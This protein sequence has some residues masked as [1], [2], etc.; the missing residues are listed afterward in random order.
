MP[1]RVDVITD[2]AGTGLP[3]FGNT[4]AEVEVHTGNG[5]GSTNTK[6]RRFS[7]VL[8]DVGGDIDYAESSTLGSSFTINQDGIYAID[9][10]ENGAVVTQFAISKN[11]SDLTADPN[12]LDPSERLGRNNATGFGHIGAIVKLSSGDVIRAHTNAAGNDTTDSV[13]FRI[14][15]LIKL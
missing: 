7:T 8:T 3:R 15:Q 14:V 10:V 11:A 1:L 2:S 6:I 13:Q 5:H 12:T 4:T 9:Y